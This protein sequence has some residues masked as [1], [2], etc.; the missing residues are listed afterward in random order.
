MPHFF[1]AWYTTAELFTETGI[2]EGSS[3]QE[4]KRFA[5]SAIILAA[6]LRCILQREPQQLAAQL[7]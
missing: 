5:K 4:E 1:S 2:Q 7:E 6:T 3:L